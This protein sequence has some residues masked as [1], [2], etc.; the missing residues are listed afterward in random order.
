MT[1][2]Y[3]RIGAMAA[4]GASATPNTLYAASATA[5]TSTIISTVAICNTTSTIQTYRVCI[6]TTAEFQ[7]NGYLVFDGSVSGNDSIF[8]SLG[9]T[10]DPTNRYLLASAS[11]NTV[12]FS[13]FGVENS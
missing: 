8:L 5:G 1:N 11:S 3:K 7:T 6:S 2:T 13:A 4:A 12:V 9:V 10:L